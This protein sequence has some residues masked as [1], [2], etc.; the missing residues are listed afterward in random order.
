MTDI[1]LYFV[2]LF[3][4]LEHVHGRKIIHRDVKPRYFTLALYPLNGSNFL[5]NPTTR[6]GVLVDFGLAEVIPVNETD[7]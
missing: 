2:S 4:G 7:D 3:L 1:R 5:F 6:Q